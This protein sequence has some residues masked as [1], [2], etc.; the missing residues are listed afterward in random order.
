MKG[1]AY[2]F[3][4]VLV[5]A[6]WAGLCVS[7]RFFAA[8]Q[9]A[10]IPPVA[11][12]AF[13]FP[14]LLLVA[15]LSLVC[16]YSQTKV[17]PWILLGAFGYAALYCCNATLLTG[18]GYLPSLLLLAGLLSHLFLFFA[19]RA[20]HTSS[21]AGTAALAA[22]TLT[23]IVCIWVLLLVIV[24][25]VILQAFDGLLIPGSHAV[26][27]CSALAFLGF[28]G[29][30]LSSA[31]CMVR[32]GRGTPLP[33]DQA[34]FLVTAGPYAVLRNPMAVAGI[35]QGLCLAAV[36]QSLPLLVY[37]LLGAVAWQFAVKPMEEQDLRARFG[38]PYEE[39]CARVGCW[40]PVAI[41]RRIAAT[42]ASVNTPSVKC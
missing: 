20:F 36:F 25:L 38:R 22:K 15:G 26:L 7:D 17:A 1:T 8:F 14:D 31:A 2:L 24:P 6:W 5:V 12:W 11:F 27:F 40:I 30:G 33:T 34:A 42:L 3:Q 41:L 9:F 23:Q 4:A 28:S 29:L 35:G 21:T 39:Y 32:Y 10:G 13:L 16:A 37:S 18:S 19:D